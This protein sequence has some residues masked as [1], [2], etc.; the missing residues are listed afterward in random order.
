MNSRFTRVIS[1]LLPLWLFAALLVACQPIQATG[2]K[3]Q[4]ASLSE[5]EQFKQAVM[6]KEAAYNTGDVD[7]FVTFFS[8]DTVSMPPGA[9]PTVGKAALTAAMRDLYSQYE[10]HGEFEL[11]SMEIVGDYATRTGR[12]KDTLTPKAGGTAI[13]D[14]GSCV[15]GWKK[16]NGEWKIIWEIWNSEPLTAAQ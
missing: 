9:V 6:A 8:D 15:A 1:L 10:V 12:W 13:S 7:Q 4:A 5:E 16:I 2:A 14:M 3:V 11:L